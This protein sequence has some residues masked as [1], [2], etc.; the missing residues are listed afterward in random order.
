MRLADDDVLIE[1]AQLIG[2]HLDRRIGEHS[3]GLLEGGRCEEGVDL[4]E[5]A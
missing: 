2:S 4:S 1:A 3:C 5:G